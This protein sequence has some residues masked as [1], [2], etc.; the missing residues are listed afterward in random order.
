MARSRLTPRT[1]KTKRVVERNIVFARLKSSKM[2]DFKR[3]LGLY[4]PLAA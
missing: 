4:V 2:T 3:A 1:R